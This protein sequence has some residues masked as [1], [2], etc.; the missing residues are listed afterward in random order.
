MTSEVKDAEQELC[1]LCCHNLSQQTP[2]VSTDDLYREVL[3]FGKFSALQQVSELHSGTKAAYSFKANFLYALASFRAT[4]T[5]PVLICHQVVP[6]DLPVNQ[7]KCYLKLPVPPGH[8][9]CFLH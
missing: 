9:I 5:T 4:T 6:N 8:S 2:E 3:C 1:S 7:V